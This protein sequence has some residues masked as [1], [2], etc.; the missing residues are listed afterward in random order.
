MFSACQFPSTDSA[1]SRQLF[2][3]VLR[4]NAHA[5]EFRAISHQLEKNVLSIR[6]YKGH[7]GQ[8]DD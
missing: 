2:Q 1:L 5:G 7:V 3:Y 4:E 6:T 8:I